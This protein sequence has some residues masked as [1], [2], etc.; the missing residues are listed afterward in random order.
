MW[1]RLKTLVIVSA[2][3]FFSTASLNSAH[4]FFYGLQIGQ[5]G[6]P[7]TIFSLN[8]NDTT[9][10]DPNIGSI[11][12]TSDCPS[13]PSPLI[14][15]DY[16]VT[17]I[18][19]DLHKPHVGTMFSVYIEGSTSSATPSALTVLASV[20][21]FAEG[22]PVAPD[23]LVEVFISFWRGSVSGNAVTSFD[24]RAWINPSN[25]PFNQEVQLPYSTT[26]VKVA[27]YAPFSVTQEMT[28]YTDIPG[29]F[30][31]SSRMIVQ[32]VPAALPLMVSA[33]AAI[34]FLRL[35]R[36]SAA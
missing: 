15:G 13:C 36:R 26:K 6:Q 22:W 23:G 35:R 21:D 20:N 12:F 16:T 17:K 32:P 1:L 2:L 9:D 31:A 25:T 18:F 5:S 29:D 28:M 8:D 30:T 14:I 27:N 24:S 7:G 19:S 4:A 11:S 33:F 10:L 3:M 34:G